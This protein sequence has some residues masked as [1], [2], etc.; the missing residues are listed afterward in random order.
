MIVMLCVWVVVIIVLMFELLSGLVSLVRF[1]G[2]RK[3]VSCVFGNI[4]RL[5]LGV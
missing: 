4:M 3:L 5:V 2:L 1:D